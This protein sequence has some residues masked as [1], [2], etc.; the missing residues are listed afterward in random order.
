[1]S[2]C[3]ST[4]I[5]GNA[6][7]V[8]RG[9]PAKT[10]DMCYSDPPFGNKQM[11]SGKAGSFSDK[12][13]A[14]SESDR[15]WI[16]LRAHSCDGADLLVAA[17][18]CNPAS[19]PYLGMMAGLL[20][21][22]RRSLKLNGTLW[23]HFDDTMGAY[24]R[25][26]GDIV[27]GPENCIGTLVWKRT[28]GSK[29]NANKFG[30]VHDTIAVWGRSRASR[31]KLWRCGRAAGDP[32]T[33]SPDVHFN[34]FANAP[35]LGSFSTKERVGYPTQKPLALLEELIL[36]ATVVG[37]L[38]CDPTC[39]SGT[40]LVAAQRLSR[41]AIGIDISADAI[42]TAARRLDVTPAWQADL[43]EAAE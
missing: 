39:G 16:S 8:L 18:Q 6:V 35:P 20:V 2:A 5:H 33:R 28:M 34:D 22:I 10:I 29:G 12:W 1:M 42:S 11:W 24:L 30:R 23:L 25:L 43:F 41:S 14:S 19:R 13:S 32:I 17:T 9:R 31:F 38:I 7:D 26:V 36:A 37:D 27:F 21:E 4:L 40:A 3:T 15:G